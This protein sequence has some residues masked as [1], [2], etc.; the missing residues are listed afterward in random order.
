MTNNPMSGLDLARVALQQAR[1]AA[2]AA[3][4]PKRRMGASA[5]R[6]DARTGGRDPLTFA[7]AIER[8]MA[9]R[10]WDMAA[11]G[12][13]ILDQW[14]TIAPELAGKVAAVKFDDETRTLHLRPV[15]QAYRL[16]LDLHQRQVIDK[17]NAKVGDGTV[18]QLKVLAPGAVDTPTPASTAAADTPDRKPAQPPAPKPKNPGY[19]AAIAAHQEHKNTRERKMDTLVRAAVQRQNH[20]LIQRREPEEAFTE[21]AAQM[22]I[23]QAQHERVQPSD[24]LEASIR[25]ARTYKH[26]RTDQPVR[27]AFDVA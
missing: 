20:L 19:L 10:G 6:R 13:S 26:R 15:S 22:E 27:R 25:A 21:I 24:S 23:L 11:K 8:M 7:A 12:G 18:Q 17:V 5:S 3:P 9:E 2:K 14:P 4:Q 16:Q 1:A